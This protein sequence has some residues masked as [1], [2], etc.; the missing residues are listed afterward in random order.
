MCEVIALSVQYTISHDK[1]LVHLRI[2]YTRSE[3]TVGT[4]P[5]PFLNVMAIYD[6]YSDLL[7]FGFGNLTQVRVT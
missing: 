3:E 1:S 6:D 5:C 2:L 4:S 7:R